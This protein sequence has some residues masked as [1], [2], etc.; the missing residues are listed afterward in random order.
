MIIAAG[1]IDLTKGGNDNKSLASKLFNAQLISGA[2]LNTASPR[3][4]DV[5]CQHV[6]ETGNVEALHG[7]RTRD[8]NEQRGAG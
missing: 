1:K 4:A 3:R 5:P 6:F 7:H 2:A 8:D